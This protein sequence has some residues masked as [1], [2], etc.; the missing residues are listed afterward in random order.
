MNFMHAHLLLNHVPIFTSA[1]GLVLLAA[2]FWW[3][4]ADVT[5]ASLWLF[6]AGGISAVVAYLTG[7][8]AAEALERMPDIS[9]VLIE[10]HEEA[11]LYAVIVVGG[12]GLLALFTLWRDRRPNP[13]VWL[14]HATLVVAL[15]GNAV[16]AR[17]AYLGGAIRHPEARSDFVAPSAAS[18]RG[19]SAKGVER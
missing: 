16:M 15:L 14:L 6:A 12:L 5:R 19:S 13:P 1:I 11:A 9:E 10:S 18:E 17:T 3:K 8:E 2:G 7:D 4:S